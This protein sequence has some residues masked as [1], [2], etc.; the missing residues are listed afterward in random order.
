MI[1][2]TKESA[3]WGKGGSLF[4][5]T[6]T[7]AAIALLVPGSALASSTAASSL[8]WIANWVLFF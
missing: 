2:S 3:L 4:G 7:V 8:G 1:K 5:R 6:A